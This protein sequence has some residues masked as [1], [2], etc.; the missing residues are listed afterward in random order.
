MNAHNLD[1]GLLY[2]DGFFTTMKVVDNQIHRWPLHLERISFSAERLKFHQL[3]ADKIYHDLINFIAKQPEKDGALRLT[4]SRGASGKNER[5]YGIPKDPTYQF[6][7]QWSPLNLSSIAALGK[8]VTLAICETPI[9]QNK[10]LAGIKHL[11]RLDQVLATSEISE[12]CFDSIMLNGKFM[13][14]G[15]KSNIYFYV[16]NRWLTPKVNKAGVNG[17]ARRWLLHTQNNVYQSKFGLEILGRAEYCLV[18]NAI[19]GIIPVTQIQ[20][21][22]KVVTFKASP[23]LQQL[24]ADY[25]KVTVNY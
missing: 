2:G 6:Y 12:D 17:T 4:I 5:G 16:K 20:L 8:G 15:S 13:I 10:A 23:D 14:C 11:N 7:M 21:A 9:S 18:S 24:Q 25:N 19:V 1:R 22:D 3:D